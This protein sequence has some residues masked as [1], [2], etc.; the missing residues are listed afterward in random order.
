MDG[1]EPIYIQANL[2]IM[3]IAKI[4]DKKGLLRLLASVPLEGSLPGRLDSLG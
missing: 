2:H 1:T 3:I 4:S